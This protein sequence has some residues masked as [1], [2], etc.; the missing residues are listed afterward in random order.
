MPMLKKNNNNGK[1]KL[2]TASR[3]AYQS[4]QYEKG[5]LDPSA[6]IY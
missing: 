3:E 4:S 6:S 5:L 1:K 2:L